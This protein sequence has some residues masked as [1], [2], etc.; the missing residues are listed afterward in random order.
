MARDGARI[1]IEAAAGGETNDHPDGLAAVEIVRSGGIGS[2]RLNDAQSAM[3][4]T[5]NPV[6]RT[7]L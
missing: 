4:A 6:M 5:A 7:P 2:L 3:K 1:L